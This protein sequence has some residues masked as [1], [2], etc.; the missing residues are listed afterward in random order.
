M[1]LK[2]RLILL[3]L[4]SGLVNYSYA[5]NT[6]GAACNC[7]VSGAVNNGVCT[8]ECTSSTPTYQCIA[9]SGAESGGCAVP[10]TPMSCE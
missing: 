8:L 9:S 10:T 1:K 7:G 4:L 3:T 5:C 2:Q 6:S